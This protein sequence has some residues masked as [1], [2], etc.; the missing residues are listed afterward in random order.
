MHFNHLFIHIKFQQEY[1]NN[2][3]I[4]HDMQNIQ[5]SWPSSIFMDLHAHEL[6]LTEIQQRFGL[7]FSS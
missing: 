5:A 3:H 2:R 4:N 6:R 1:K 7:A